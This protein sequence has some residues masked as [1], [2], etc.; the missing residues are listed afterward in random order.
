MHRG[1]LSATCRVDM[2]GGAGPETKQL[3]IVGVHAFDSTRKRMSV[4]VAES[5]GSATV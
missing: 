4:V 5:D 2:P 1:M 3:K